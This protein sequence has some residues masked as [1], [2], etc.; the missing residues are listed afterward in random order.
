MGTIWFCLVAVMIAVYVVLD[1]FDIG[2]GIL[3]LW[4]PRPTTSAVSHPHHRPGVGRQRSLAPR[5]RWHALLRVSRAIR[6]RL[7]RIL[8]A[9]DDGAVAPDPARNL[10]RISQPRR[11]P[12]LV[13]SGTPS[14]PSPASCSRFFSAPRLA[15]WFAAFRS[16]QRKLLRAA[17]DQFPTGDK[18]EFSIGTQS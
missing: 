9:A 5:R 13:L 17:L 4:S 2:V 10:H 7:Q 6:R 12:H 15:T 3:H 1:G 11:R 16:I 18:P 14:S 8:S